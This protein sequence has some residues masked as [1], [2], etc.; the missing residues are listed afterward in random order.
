MLGVIFVMIFIALL[1][2]K[3]WK[4]A[5]TSKKKRVKD[6]SSC[7]DKLLINAEVHESLNSEKNYQDNGIR[8]HH[9]KVG[10]V[11]I[12]ADNAK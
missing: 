7:P 12:K 4:K 3:F 8:N 11:F 9:E 1:S 6:T 5:G 10:A 2:A